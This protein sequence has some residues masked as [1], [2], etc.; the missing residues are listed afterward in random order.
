MKRDLADF[1][2]NG[3][4]EEGFERAL[5]MSVVDP[6]A[7]ATL[8]RG[9]EVITST[10]RL[11]SYALLVVVNF[12]D[13]AKTPDD[14]A[15]NDRLLARY[16]GRNKVEGEAVLQGLYGLRQLGVFSDSSS[17]PE[18][19]HLVLNNLDGLLLEYTDFRDIAVVD[20]VLESEAK[21]D[22]QFDYKV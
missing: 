21:K 16:S 14:K 12:S 22:P 10:V 20:S 15:L 13:N 8:Y 9:N 5:T 4:K 2:Q 11:P 1:I 6:A 17:D 19:N 18:T 3:L 7:E